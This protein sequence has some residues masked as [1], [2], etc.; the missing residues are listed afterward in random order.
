MLDVPDSDA[1]LFRGWVHDII[2]R[3]DDIAS[4]V[5][6]S[7]ECLA[8]FRAQ[9]AQRREQP[10]EDI[11]SLLARSEIEGVPLP[12]RTIAAAGFVVLV[13]GIDTV[14][15]TL[16]AAILHLARHPEDLRRLQHDPD[17][18]DTAIEE[19]LRFYAPVELSRL[20]TRD[21]EL[22]GSTLHAGEHVLLSF[23][24]AN[25]DPEVF[26]DADTF[27]IDRAHNRHLPS[28]WASIAASDPTSPA[29][30]CTS[31]SPRGYDA[32]PASPSTYPD[33]LK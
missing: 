8:Y 7:R 1:E 19:F 17:L 4:Q 14:W 6:A 18:L 15:T 27:V 5:R 11:I 22:G 32:F 20:V 28:A 16:G 13:A 33:R 29:W 26:P 21:T 25:R 30:N 12:D 3:P 9:L 23:P 2:E 24:A 10:G 31:H